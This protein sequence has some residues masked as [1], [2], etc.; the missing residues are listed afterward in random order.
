M[1]E[2]TDEP[3]YRDRACG[4]DIGQGRHGGDD[5][6]AVGQD[7][8]AGGRDPQLSAP[9]ERKVLALADWLRCRAQAPAVVME[10]T[11]DYWKGPCYRLEAEGFQGGGA[12][13]RNRLKH[14]PGCPKRDPLL[15]RGR[16]SLKRGAITSCFVATPE[17]RVIRAT[18]ATGGT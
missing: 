5:P 16:R 18:P 1:E 6:G 3:L 9:R 12:D 7:G 8:A 13:A 2:V 17:F 14:P 15:S 11:S 10:A 4:I